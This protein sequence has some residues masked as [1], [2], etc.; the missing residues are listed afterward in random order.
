[1]KKKILIIYPEM[2]IG[3]TTT[4]L[5]S[6]LN[7]FD[8]N[9]YEID[10]QMQ[11]NYG[12]LSSKIPSHIN[13]LPLA[14]PLSHSFYKY[15]KIFS[16]V[17]VYKYLHSRHQPCFFR[18]QCMESDIVKFS[19][20][21]KKEYDIAISF[22]ELWSLYYLVKK[23]R[24]KK[25]IAW[26]HLDYSAAQLSIDFDRFYFKQ[27]DNI[28]LVSKSCLESFQNLAPDFASKSIAI[29]NILSQKIIQHRSLEPLS[30]DLREKLDNDKRIKM[31]SVCRITFADK[32]LDRG[33]Y[34]MVKLRDLGLLNNI[35]W[36]IVG[37]GPDYE[38]LK[39]MIIQYDLENH[40]ELLGAYTNPY[41]IESKCDIFFLPSRYE[42]K[43]MA[44]TETLMLG[45]VPLVSEYKSAHEQI[46]DK[47]DGIICENS[48]EG[49]FKGL[50]FVVKHLNLVL[51]ELKENVKSTDYTNL[52]EFKRIE[53]LLN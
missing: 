16:P 24:A 30:Q 34:A 49:I 36:Y 21:N 2:I 23:V 9:R 26:I 10:L 53:Q 31:I 35:V 39:E 37:D 22:M 40:I 15:I 47:Y 42:G 13:L 51:T 45:L 48:D 50:E 17:S 33:V 38:K 28:V 43:P 41:N 3:G 29:E 6:I 12:I 27:V 19:H 14:L 44:V 52:D 7:L 46:K 32:G 11:Y 8:P 1:M 18:S 20:M 25:K 4:S 5:L